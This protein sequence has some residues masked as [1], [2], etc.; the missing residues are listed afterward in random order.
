MYIDTI[1]TRHVDIFNYI[2]ASKYK[3]DSTTLF[4]Y[5]KCNNS[6]LVH[7][8][9]IEGILPPPFLRLPDLENSLLSHNIEE[10]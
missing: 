3:Q 10:I 7:C 9:Y 6:C 1:R 5:F 4:K 2:K 8:T